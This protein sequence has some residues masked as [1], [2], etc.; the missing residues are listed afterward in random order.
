MSGLKECPFCGGKA[1]RFTIDDDDCFNN[2]NGDVIEC[3]RC[4]ISSKV[5]FGEKEHMEEAWNTR[6]K[7]E[8]LQQALR[9]A[10]EEMKGANMYLES[11]GI[12]KEEY[13]G[14]AEH[15]MFHSFRKAIADIKE[16]LNETSN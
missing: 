16:V 1:N 13:E 7:E 8:K 2:F 12:N 10:M 3:K 15:Q 4:R 9:D 6:P 14:E 11:T 5:V